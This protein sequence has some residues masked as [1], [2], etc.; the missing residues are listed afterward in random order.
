MKE[1]IEATFYYLGKRDML[2]EIF[3][4]ININKMDY[5]K[6]FDELAKLYES[7]FGDNCHIESF[8]K[9]NKKIK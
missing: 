9:I 3:M 5:D 2:A 8:K 7:Q 6:T 1:S 4:L